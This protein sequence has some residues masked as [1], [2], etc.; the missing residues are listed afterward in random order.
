MRNPSLIT[1]WSLLLLQI[2]GCSTLPPSR[3]SLSQDRAPDRVVDFNRI[4][5]A[6]PRPEPL[7]RYGNPDSYVVQGKRYYRL[8]SSAGYSKRGT[9]SWYGEK[10]HGH[11]TSSG[12]PF[13]MYRMTAAHK[14]LP[15]PTYA[16]VTNL[17]NGRS[18]VVK[19]ND[20]GPF[21]DDRIIDLSYAAAGKL[22]I[23][24]KGTGRVEVVTLDPKNTRPIQAAQKTD[25]SIPAIHY[26]QVGAF[27]EHLNAANLERQLSDSFSSDVKVRSAR[28]DRGVVYRVQVGPFI[29]EAQAISARQ[30]LQEMGMPELVL[31]NE[32][33]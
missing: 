4:P 15:L 17:E 27:K 29:S 13:N 5:D 10:F 6:T 7:S 32:T 33:P 31:V 2:Y 25:S 9:A 3:Y 30:Q 14:T 28:T 21:H 18:V 24:A 22:G 19:I 16:R 11:R 1:A 23:L 12:E 20:R 8:D 26:V